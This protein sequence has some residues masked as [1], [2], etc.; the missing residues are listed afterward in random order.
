MPR[1]SG[2]WRRSN[3]PGSPGKA[4]TT[5]GAVITVRTL[6]EAI[7]L[8][9]RIAPEHLEIQTTDAEQLSEKVR[10]AGAIFLGAYTPGSQSATILA[11]RTMSCRP[12]A[13]HGFSSGLSVLDFMKRTTIARMTPDALKAIGPAAETLAR[14]ESLEAHGLSVSAR[15]ERLN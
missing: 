11:A 4:G 10:H 2:G 9:N 7:P 15:L 1:S 5:Y 13:R 12:R 6:D 3:D 14:S 8:T